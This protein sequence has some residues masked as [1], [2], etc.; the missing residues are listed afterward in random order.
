M[1]RLPRTT[2]AKLLA[3]IPKMQPWTETSKD[4][5][6]ALREAGKQML[7]YGSTEL[8]LSSESGSFRVSVVNPRTGEV[9]AGETMKTGNKAKLPDATVVWLTKE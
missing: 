4:G 2:D 1:P 5:R 6:W 8:D 9:T 3:A 7:V